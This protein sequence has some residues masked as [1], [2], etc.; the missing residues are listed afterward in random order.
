MAGSK[1]YASKKSDH[2]CQKRR[3]SRQVD[4]PRFLATDQSQPSGVRF[5]LHVRSGRHRPRT[6]PASFITEGPKRH[7][8]GCCVQNEA[9]LRKQVF[10][11]RSGRPRRLQTSV[12]SNA[13]TALRELSSLLPDHG[14]LCVKSLRGLL[15]RR[16]VITGALCKPEEGYA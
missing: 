1:N 5:A 6:K 13:K 4:S 15:S 10:E 14:T 11:R 8:R 3:T 2:R 12:L 16:R 9:H 7:S